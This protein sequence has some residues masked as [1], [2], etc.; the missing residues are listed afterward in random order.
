MTQIEKLE[1]D[2]KET[3]SVLVS[4]PLYQA[5]NSKE[6]LII[7]MEDHVFA[8]WDFMSLIKAL[9]RNL[10]CV[11]VPWTPNSNNFSGKLVNEIVLAEESDVD[12]NNNPKS[13]FELYLESMELQ[14]ANTTLINSF[15]KEIKDSHSYFDSAKKSNYLK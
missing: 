3:R 7:F 9:Q 6:K 14:G 4:H 15:V 2:L 12:L 10:T 8:V 1:N 13:H 5:L 11:N